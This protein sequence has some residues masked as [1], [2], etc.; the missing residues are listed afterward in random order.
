MTKKTLSKLA[1]ELTLNSKK[2]SPQNENVANPNDS[3]KRGFGVLGFWGF[4]VLG[5]WG[6]ADSR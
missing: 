6:V 2:K 1:A 4:G 5:F 3:I